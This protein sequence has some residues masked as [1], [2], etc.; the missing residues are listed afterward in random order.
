MNNLQKLIKLRGLTVSAIAQEIGH[1][2]HITQKIIKRVTRLR[3]DGAVVVR[4]N[5]KIEE[6]VAKLIGITW[7]ECWGPES[8]AALPRLLRLEI[9]KQA[10]QRKF[11]L[12]KQWLPSSNVPKKRK[13]NN[14]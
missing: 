7:G 10:N 11:D 2:Y 12:R 14:V 1:G 5:R 4:S 8:E 13:V 3:A 6:A 9:E